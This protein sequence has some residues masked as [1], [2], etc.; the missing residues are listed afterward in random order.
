MM[1]AAIDWQEVRHLLE[2]L[3]K[4]SGRLAEIFYGRKFSL[5]G[6]LVG[7]IGEVIAAYMFDLELVTASS[8]AHD[9]LAPDR[10]R[11]EIKMTQGAKVSLRHPAE[12]LL[13]L[14]RPQGGPVCIVYNGP[15]QPVWD[16]ARGR[17]SDRV[18]R[19]SSNGQY[20]IGV[21]TIKELDKLVDPTKRLHPKGPA[22]V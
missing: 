18:R 7:S 16:R 17:S 19:R 22:P 6:H 5:D 4:A 20:S 3:Y 15:G 21:K 14:H 8:K 11:V 1:N 10:R 12:H 13:V 2:D 9:A